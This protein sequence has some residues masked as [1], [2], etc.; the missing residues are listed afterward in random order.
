MPKRSPI[1]CLKCKKK[2]DTVNPQGHTTAKDRWM[3]KGACKQ[4]GSGKSMFVS[5][6]N[7]GGGWGDLFSAVAPALLGA[8]L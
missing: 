3:V 1:H 5:K 8:F 2:T 6:Q 7:G 4:C